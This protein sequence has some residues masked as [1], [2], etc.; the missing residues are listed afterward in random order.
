MP[1]NEPVLSYKQ[2][3]GGSTVP[4]SQVVSGARTGDATTVG[5]M[6]PGQIALQARFSGIGMVSFQQTADTD[7]T[8]YSHY[9]VNGDG[10][11]AVDNIVFYGTLF[12]GQYTYLRLHGLTLSSNITYLPYIALYVDDVLGETLYVT[13]SSGSGYEYFGMAADLSAL[14]DDRVYGFYVVLGFEGTATMADWVKA[15]GFVFFQE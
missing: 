4:R 1:K 6:T 14:E 2:R 7:A 8:K 9:T 13:A 15:G 3:P 10:L 5:G 11:G 12:T